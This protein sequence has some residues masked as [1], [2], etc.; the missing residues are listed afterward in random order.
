MA[1]LKNTTVNDTGFLQLPAGTTEQRPSPLAGQL[2]YNTTTSKAEFYDAAGAN[3]VGSAFGGVIATGGTM[4]DVDVDGTTYRVH[5]FTT[6]GNSTFTVTRGGPIEYLIVAGGGGGGGTRHAGGGG[7]GG[8]LTGTITVTPQSYTFT[9]GA[10]G[11]GGLLGGSNTRGVSGA[12][13]SAFGLTTIGGGGA[14]SS[15]NGAAFT[16]GSGGG[17]GRSDTSAAGTAGQGNNGGLG[18]AALNGQGA[19]GG[20]A[21]GVGG[22]ALTG[23]PGGNGGVGISTSITGI[24]QLYAGGGGAGG[25]PYRAGGT[26]GF[27]GA[28]GGGN[29]TNL[30]TPGVPGTPNTGGGGGGC[31]GDASGGASDV[32][33]PGGAGGSGVVIVR[34][35]LR[36]EHPVTAPGKEISNGLILD[37]DFSKPAVYTGSGTIVNDS[38]LNGIT[39]SLINGPVYSDNRSHRSGFRF[40]QAASGTLETTL[41][42]TAIPASLGWTL[43]CMV[44]LDAFPTSG[45]RKNGVLLGAAYYTGA[46][47]YWQGN[48]AGTSFNVFGYV[49]TT[50]YFGTN[51]ASLALNTWYHLMVVQDPVALRLGLYLNGSLFS[52]VTGTNTNYAAS[53][54]GI[55]GNIGINRAQVDGGGS[56]TYTHS[57]STVA[58]ARV[59]N[60][61]LTAAE[62]A[63]NF[64]ATRWRF[65]I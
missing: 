53:E 31:G 54:A 9:V 23:F 55:A 14:G 49:R 44:R 45:T 60:R 63:N 43:E 34:Y 56:E 26:P 57:T 47:I 41:P 25:A 6:T 29:G 1:I 46:A 28:G 32:G 22:P 35:P 15:T 42:L 62:V 17:A 3:W 13:S 24:R 30:T 40:T 61:A 27:G 12:N 33:A 51:A 20:G 58:I 11:A 64:N 39:G 19:G 59:Y 5:A 8:L 36:Q 7:A 18:N 38:R 10:G 2:R 52:E 37:L 48:T 16:G 65:G 21:G 4:Y 50:G